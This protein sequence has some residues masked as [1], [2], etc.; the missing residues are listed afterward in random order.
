MLAWC[1]VLTSMALLT[2]MARA[3]VL[4]TM[5]RVAGYDDAT[6]VVSMVSIAKTPCYV[7]DIT[8][9]GSLNHRPRSSCRSRL[10]RRRTP[11]EVPLGRYNQ[12]EPTVVLRSAI[13]LPVGGNNPEDIHCAISQSL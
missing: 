4:G 3:F 9:L 12:E 13:P 8:G 11:F 7:N 5:S 1:T 10:E 6:I 2:V